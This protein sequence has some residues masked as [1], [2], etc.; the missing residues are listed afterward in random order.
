M[1]LLIFSLFLLFLSVNKRGLIKYAIMIV[2][3]SISLLELINFSFIWCEALLLS[4]CLYRIDTFL[5][6]LTF[7]FI[8][9]QLFFI[10]GNTILESLCISMVILGFSMMYFA[11]CT[12]AINIFVTSNFS[13]IFSSQHLVKFSYFLESNLSSECL[14]RLNRI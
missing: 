1:S 12:F 6:E 4:A 8:Y 7:I 2:N 11:L 10:S 5:D 13:C 3:L 14:A 9:N